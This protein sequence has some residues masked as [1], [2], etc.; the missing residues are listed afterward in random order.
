MKYDGLGEELRNGYMTW[1][2]M[3]IYTKAEK[4]RDKA[5]MFCMG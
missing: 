1:E 2:Y 3:R 4:L 5:K